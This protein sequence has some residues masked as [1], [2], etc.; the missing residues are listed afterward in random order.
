MISAPIECK[1]SPVELQRIWVRRGEL[2]S[3]VGDGIRHALMP[4]VHVAVRGSIQ[5]QSAEAHPSSAGFFRHA[6]LF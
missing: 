4:G 1:P 5:V 6:S 2:L 3:W